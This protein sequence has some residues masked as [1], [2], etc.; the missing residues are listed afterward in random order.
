MCAQLTTISQL[1]ARD[2]GFMKRKAWKP[3]N[4]AEF[5]GSPCSETNALSR[6]ST[7]FSELFSGTGSVGKA[8]TNFGYKVMSFDIEAIYQPAI[9]GDI[10][11]WDYTKYPRGMFR[12]IIH[13]SVPCSSL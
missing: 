5:S 6:I 7:E 12:V 2:C 4:I 8:A 13:S 3:R 1:H 11:N 9:V 10:M